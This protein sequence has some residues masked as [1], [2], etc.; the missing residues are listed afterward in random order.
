MLKIYNTLTKKKEQF[1]PLGATVKMYN[2]GPT[3]YDY[4]HIGNFRAYIFADLLRR[5]LEYSGLKVKQIMNI[6]DVGHMTV[7]DVADGEGED[8]IEKS[9]KKE[10]KTPKEVSEFYTDAFFADIKKLRIQQAFDYPKASEHIE[11]MIELVK[12]LIDSGYAYINNGSV[13]YDITK[14]PK[15]GKLSGNTIK[16]LM[17]GARIEPHPD[18][19]NPYDFALWKKDENHLMK[20]E[21]PWGP[22]RPGWHLE[23]SAMSMKYLGDSLDIHT[24]GVDNIFP[25][26]ESEIAQSEAATGKPFVKYWLHTTHLLVDGKKMSKSLGNFYTLRDILKKGYDPVAIRYLLLS[27][28]YRNQ[29]N[30]TFKEL[31]SAKTT[32]NNINNFLEKLETADA[33]K[34]DNEELQLL[35]DETR[36]KFE[37]AMNDDLNVPEALSHVFNMIK[38]FNREIDKKKADRKS[39]KSAYSFFKDLNK[40]LDIVEE[41]RGLTTTEKK[42]IAEREALRKKKKFKEADEVRSKL[43]SMGIIIED[44]PK[45]TQW[46]R[47]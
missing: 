5:Y 17:A 46:K 10:H 11:E 21:S 6:T 19:K 41:K 32:V 28:H 31:E 37:E 36:D 4:A 7:D 35:V 44:T 15:Y 14:F 26:H 23:C 43:E 3:V 42:L 2:C 25:H 8:K 38:V 30:F 40:I 27:S 34:T 13:Y 24:G 1:L 18:K 33:S 12:K 47:K 22:G 39:L 9:A 29:L 20:W 45:G 16:K